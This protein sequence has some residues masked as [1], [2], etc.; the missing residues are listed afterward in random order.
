MSKFRDGR[1][2]F[3]N[4]RVKGLKNGAEHEIFSANKYEN[5]NNSWHFHIIREILRNIIREKVEHEKSFIT[6]IGTRFQMSNKMPFSSQLPD[7]KSNLLVMHMQH[8]L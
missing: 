3:R 5:A 8:L 2:Y 7:D 6:S 4:S 1:V